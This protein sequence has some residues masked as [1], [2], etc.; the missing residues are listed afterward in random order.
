MAC[1]DLTPDI[2]KCIGYGKELQASAQ[3]FLGRAF[4]LTAPITIVRSSAPR[5]IFW[6]F[7]AKNLRD[8]A[9][10]VIAT[11]NTMAMVVRCD[12]LSDAD[13]L[14]CL[15]IHA[16]KAVVAESLRNFPN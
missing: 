12:L 6:R 2:D 1:A 10:Q 11:A 9:T 8:I 3:P 7:L 4:E 16:Y 14:K 5:G 13:M 15:N